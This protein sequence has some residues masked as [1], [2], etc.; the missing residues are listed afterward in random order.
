M[1]P[2]GIVTLPRDIPVI[3][4]RRLGHM[5]LG[6]D[7]NQVIADCK[8]GTR[9]AVILDESAHLVALSIFADLNQNI[10]QVMLRIWRNKTLI[11]GTLSVVGSRIRVKKWGIRGDSVHSIL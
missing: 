10:L 9:F 8:F 5:G 2:E 11:I 7:E 4:K 1:I 6:S 3:A